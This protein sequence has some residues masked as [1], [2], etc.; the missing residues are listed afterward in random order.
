MNVETARSMLINDPGFWRQ[1]AEEARRLAERPI[2]KTAKQ[3]MLM[4]AEVCDRFAIGAAMC[5]V[6]E[7]ALSRVIDK[8]VT[9][10]S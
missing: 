8:T 3:T 2:D 6:Y 7:L 9:A 1:R 10:R 5:S 4:V